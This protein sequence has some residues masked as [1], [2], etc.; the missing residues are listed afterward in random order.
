MD[1]QPIGMKVADR[2]REINGV[3]AIVDTDASIE[4]RHPFNLELIKSQLQVLRDGVGIA[5]DATVTPIA[6]SAWNS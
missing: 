3:H 6:V 2:F 4:G 1:L 5:F